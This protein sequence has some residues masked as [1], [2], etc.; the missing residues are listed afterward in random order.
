M[1]D[2]IQWLMHDSTGKK[3]GLG[4]LFAVALIV[5]Y[6]GASMLKW[7]SE[8][9]KPIMF[10]ALVIAGAVYLG[11]VLNAG[12]EL[13]AVIIGGCIAGVGAIGYAMSR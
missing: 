9:F 7:A 13:W 12:W 2:I 4:L 1:N 10:A 6:A 5:S 8:H 11:I 3:V